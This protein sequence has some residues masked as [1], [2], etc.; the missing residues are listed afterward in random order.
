MKAAFAHWDNRI[1]PVFDIARHIHL[2]E[3]ESGRIT[4]E[5]KEIFPDDVPVQKALRLTELG[6]N[7][8]VCGAISRPLHELVGSY[9]IRVIPFVTGDLREVIRAWLSGGLH[10]DTFT[11][12]GC[13]SR[14]RRNF[15]R[16][17]RNKQKE[18]IIMPRGDGT[19]PAGT[20]R[21]HGQGR[22]GQGN[23][24]GGGRMG[25]SRAGGPSG[26]CVCPTCGHREP[27]GRAVSCIQKK[28]PKCGTA[29][30][31]E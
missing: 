21:G 2:V 12:P 7:T 13:C 29:L 14:I 6:V 31:R 23:G 3:I 30:T 5:T 26:F 17:P 15:Q 20:G 19:G 24:Q 1:A 18:E 11:M 10:G 8:L 4:G 28:C 16:K 27:H 9:G 22:G 25:G